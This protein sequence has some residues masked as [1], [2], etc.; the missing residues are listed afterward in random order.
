MNTDQLPK[1][2]LKKIHVNSKAGEIENTA[3]SL[4][5]IYQEAGLS[6]VP[7]LPAMMAQVNELDNSLVIAINHLRSKSGLS[8]LDTERDQA[9][10]ALSY[11]IL[12]MLYH[13]DATIV[14]AAGQVNRVLEHYSRGIIRESYSVE[15]SLLD[16]LLNDLSTDELVAAIAQLPSCAALVQSL[17][18][19]QKAFKKAQRAYL[20]T[21]A[22]YKRSPK[23][24]QIRNQL[25]SYLNGLVLPY[26]NAMFLVDEPLYG[27]LVRTLAAVINDN[28]RAVN[29]RQGRAKNK[30]AASPRGEAAKEV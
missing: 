22:E 19:K 4:V 27:Q 16:S 15:N 13:S 1:P 18:N 25:R 8:E 28:N 21:K 30:K 23:A 5:R 26:L 2:I 10:K 17:S 3:A 11:F 29:R 9:M 20:E 7:Y 12:S 24:W 14:K 6:E